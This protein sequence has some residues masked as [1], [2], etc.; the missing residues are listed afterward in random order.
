M[1]LERDVHY[2]RITDP[3]YK[4]R[5]LQDISGWVDLQDKILEKPIHTKYC[6]L[7]TGGRIIGREGYAWDGAS[8]PTID[9]QSSMHCSLDHDILWQLIEEGYLDSSWYPVSNDHLESQGRTD[10][11]WTPRAKLWNLSVTCL[12]RPFIK[13]KKWIFGRN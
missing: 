11:M 6:S 13:F 9:T 10:G 4:Y 12:G 2:E 8:G 7:F 1:L 3:V 5:L